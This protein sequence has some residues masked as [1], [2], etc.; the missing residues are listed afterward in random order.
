M[1]SDVGCPLP[2]RDLNVDDAPRPNTEIRRG[3]SSATDTAPVAIPSDVVSL[4]KSTR[5]HRSPSYLQD[6]QCNA[7]SPYAITNYCC[8][9]RLSP[10]YQDFIL[11]VLAVYEPQYYNQAT[12]KPEW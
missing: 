7:V 10:A 9:D 3:D 1:F 11:Q 8:Y 12:K 6:Y 5:S 4:F 2:Y